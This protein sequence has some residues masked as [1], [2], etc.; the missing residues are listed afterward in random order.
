MPRSSVRPG[1]L[2]SAAGRLLAHEVEVL[3]VRDSRRA[4]RSSPSWAAPRSPTS[5]AVIES[6]LDVVD[7][8]IVG[9]GMAFTFLTAKGHSVGSSL[10]EDDMVETCARL[11]DGA[12]PIHLP[13]TSPRSGRGQAV[14]SRGWGRGPPD[15]GVDLPE[16]WMGFDIGPGRP[17][18]SAT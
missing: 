11:L 14:R 9:G 12:Q 17:P 10:L 18:S 5:S 15:A 4:V 16:G 1:H 6:L 8:L 7:A 3:G 13:M 2:P